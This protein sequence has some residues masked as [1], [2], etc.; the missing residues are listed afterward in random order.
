M[1]LIT[2]SPTIARAAAG[3]RLR[4]VVPADG[5]A[6][7]ALLRST[8]P[9]IPVEPEAWLAEW[10]WRCWQNP[11]RGPRPVGW[12]LEDGRRL[13]GHLGAVCVPLLVGGRACTGIIGSDYAVADPHAGGLFGALQLAESLFALADPQT[14]VLA[15]TA[16]EKTA[17]VFGRYGCVP[18][19]WTREF[20]RA[21]ATKRQIAR[22]SLGGRSRVLRRIMRYPLAAGLL[23]VLHRLAGGG[24]RCRV[25]PPPW[26]RTAWPR[27]GDWAVEPSAEY[28]TWRYARH[29]R[30]ELATALTIERDGHVQAAAVTMPGL[31]D[32]CLVLYVEELVVPEGREDLASA[33]LC[34]VLRL[35][36]AQGCEWVVTTVGSSEF[37]GLMWE[38]GFESRSRNAPAL[39]IQ[40]PPPPDRVHFD[41]GLMF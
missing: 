12:V 35:A 31:R 8:L 2:T 33:L 41:H 30:G 37:S 39:L 18:V 40:S 24:M 26:D 13:L 3:P 9:D 19:T 7:H 28:L 4:E 6:I 23:G 34:D 15:S 36:H 10:A 11:F 32:G 25:E 27:A 17:A 20:W 21:P 5:P 38:L 1:S 29:P 16:N 14:T 22:S